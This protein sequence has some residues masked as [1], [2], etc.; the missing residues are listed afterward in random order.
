ML[1][2]LL[3]TGTLSLVIVALLAFA[4]ACAGEDPTPIA[5][6]AKPKP[7]AT[8]TLI[9]GPTATLVPGATAAPLPTATE[10]PQV[11]LAYGTVEDLLKNPGYKAEWGEPK[12][13]GI[14][15]WRSNWPQTNNTP[16]Y[17][18]MYRGL[19]VTPQYNHL[20]RPDPWCGFDCPLNNDLAES[21]SITDDGL[22][23]TIQLRQGVKF[24]DAVPED[25]KHGYGDMPG[26]GEVFT[27]EDAK[28]S[29]EFVATD[30]WL[31]E[32]ASG[33]KAHPKPSENTYTCTDGPQGYTL[34][35]LLHTGVP[36]PSLLLEL[37]SIGI[38]MVN[39]EWLEYLITDHPKEI[40]KTENG[41]FLN[42]GTGGFVSNELQRD[43]VT[44]MR[45]RDGYFRS[46][47]PFVD[48]MDMHVIR[49]NSTAFT[50]WASGQLD[51]L[52]QGSGSLQSGQIAQALRDFPDMPIDKHLYTGGQGLHFNTTRPP[53]DDVRVRQAVNMV[54]DRE[55][56]HELQKIS[57]GVYKN[58]ISAMFAPSGN[59]GN[60]IEDVMKWPGY[61]AD[62]AGD[63]AEA[64]RIMDE[65]YGTGVRP[66][67]TCLSRS[68]QNY[69]DR[70]IF[71]G[72]L[73]DTHLGMTVKMNITE[74]VVE[75]TLWKNCNYDLRSSWLPGLTMYL[76]PYERVRTFNS[77]D[78]SFDACRLGVNEADQTKVND[79]IYNLKTELDPVQRNEYA[80]EWERHVTLDVVYGAP[81]E[82]QT[83]YYGLSKAIKGASFEDY[84][85][86]MY[87]HHL[88]DKYWLDR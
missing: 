53:M 16:F 19:Y 64:N 49:D 36:N 47:L 9:P 28:A 48:G 52:G 26:R 30:E 76:D 3:K 17:G 14:V 82:F 58:E 34:E 63:I 38:V 15:K 44:K 77:A 18:S 21:W 5:P 72:D 71:A 74:G 51:I 43:I 41:Y 25:E 4:S 45:K 55:A 69:V 88:S 2:R 75:K 86:F 78:P 13:G 54:I 59:W 84:G 46:A 11:N 68:D 65:I 32:G 24:R 39:K 8:S 79:L 22:T 33:G 10:I 87:H 67:I 57:E 62:K 85:V 73:L 56:W 42:M 23:Y 60:P 61:G 27:C 12:Y 31:A 1:F 81:L 7:T 83:L 66:E 20:V 37:S 35:I 29:L 70:C 40:D 80:K 50:A 6:T